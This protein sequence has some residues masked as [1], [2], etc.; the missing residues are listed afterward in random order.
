MGLKNIVQVSTGQYHSMA[1]DQSGVVWTWGDNLFGQLGDG[2]ETDRIKPTPIPSLKN[3]VA[4]D[5]GGNHSLAL[6]KNG[7]VW[8][9]GRNEFF[10]LGNGSDMNSALPV[11]IKNLK[12]VKSISAG[13]NHSFALTED[14]VWAWG[15][16]SNG[17]IGNGTNNE[18]E[19]NGSLKSNQDVSIPVK[20][21]AITE[22]IKT[23]SAGFKHSVALSQNGNV[24]VWGWN[25]YGQLGSGGTADI[26]RPEKNVNIKSKV[27]GLVTGTYHSF[28]MDDSSNMY[29]WGDDTYG[30]LGDG[31]KDIIRVL[32]AVIEMK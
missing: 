23:I 4:I 17:Q 21:T 25:Q 28:A 32:P 29:I 2:S 12:Q 11:W 6:T 1:L 16:N 7:E 26:N 3:I 10:Q 27:I 20:L 9:W 19:I 14:G 13:D 30:Q 18:Y 5:A 24:Y 8:A 31:R 15:Y 22:K